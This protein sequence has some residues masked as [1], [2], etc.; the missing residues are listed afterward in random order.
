MCAP[1][2]G[3]GWISSPG[4]IGV[5]EHFN[6]LARLPG[7]AERHHVP[8]VGDKYGVQ[9][10][11]AV[12]GAHPMRGLALRQPD[13]SLRFDLLLFVTICQST[14][15]AACSRLHRPLSGEVAA[16]LLLDL[17]LLSDLI[18]SRQHAPCFSQGLFIRVSDKN[19]NYR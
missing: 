15:I 10:R 8:P 5:Y 1:S 13:Q 12:H 19:N 6:R 18:M 16:E 11:R 4:R 17:H 3:V 2:G 7:P 9:W 14:K